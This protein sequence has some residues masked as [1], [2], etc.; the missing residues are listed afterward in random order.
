METFLTLVADAFPRARL[1]SF[2]A[3][4]EDHMS[5]TNLK[6]KLTRY[7]L[8]VEVWIAADGWLLA[9]STSPPIRWKFDHRLLPAVACNA[10]R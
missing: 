4:R 9:S 7:I 8:H 1:H 2:A 10:C 3:Y 6:F 5:Q